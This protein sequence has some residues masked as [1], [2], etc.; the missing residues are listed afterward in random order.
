M[1]QSE[2]TFTLDRLDHLVLTVASIPA[3][4]AFY[5]D[6]LGMRSEKFKTATGEIRQALK[7]GASKINLH[8][9]GQ[10]FEPKAQ[11]PT[12]GSADLCFL[13]QTPIQDWQKHLAARDVTVEDGPVPRTGATGPLVSIYIRDP[14]QNLIEISAQQ[15]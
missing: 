1:S 12:P 3:T 4:V 9:Q 14:D 11:R 7:F 5:Q 6:V 10:E 8:Q 2:P 15:S 13:T